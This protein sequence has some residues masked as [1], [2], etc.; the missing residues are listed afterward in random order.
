MT[1]TLLKHVAKQKVTQDKTKKRVVGVL[2][3]VLC[4]FSVGI[5]TTLHYQSALQQAN[6]LIISFLGIMLP[7]MVF[8]ACFYSIISIWY[9]SDTHN[10]IFFKKLGFSGKQVRKIIIYEAKFYTRYPLILGGVVGLCVP[11]CFYLLDMVVFD[12]VLP[13]SLMV[14]L[15]FVC[16]FVISIS[17]LASRVCFSLCAKGINT[18]PLVNS[19]AKKQKLTKKAGKKF[20]PVIPFL[21]LQYVFYN[22]LGYLKLLFVLI[23]AGTLLVFAFSFGSSISMDAYIEQLWGNSAYKLMGM[24]HIDEDGEYTSRTIQEDNLFSDELRAEIEN[25]EGVT[26]VIANTQAE[27][28]TVMPNGETLHININGIRSIGN[29][30]EILFHEIGYLAKDRQYMLEHNGVVLS[31]PEDLPYNAG[32][33]ITVQVKDGVHTVNKEIEIVEVVSSNLLGTTFYTYP[34]VI[35]QL[36]TRN[37]TYGFRIYGEET[38]EIHQK[39]TAM[40]SRDSRFYLEDRTSQRELNK[41]GFTLTNISIGLIMA[42]LIAFGMVSFVNVCV[43]YVI[44]RKRDFN[45]LYKIGMSKKQVVTMLRTELGLLYIVAAVIALV[46]G[47]GIAKGLCALIQHNGLLYFI[48]NPSYLGFLV[49]TGLFIIIFLVVSTLSQKVLA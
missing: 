32:D 40:V 5:A 22:W 30:E 4:F 46:G 35:K 13:A 39:L 34:E 2:S 12:I 31:N 7:V 36:M 18:L 1:K 48:F 19:D 42:I 8:F 23:I 10:Y 3:C 6:T 45:I 29:T 17:L 15:L 33:V 49:F 44:S 43:S 47:L 11:L 28:A 25:L 16:F 37:P 14:E 20:R 38:E 26:Y 21:N 41:L 24:P 9:Q 27:T